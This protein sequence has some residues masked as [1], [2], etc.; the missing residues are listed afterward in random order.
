MTKRWS[1][2]RFEVSETRNPPLYRRIRMSRGW[3]KHANG[4]LVIN[5]EVRKDPKKIERK[6]VIGVTVID[7]F[8]FKRK[9]RSL[10]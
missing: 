6:K 3:M 8:W 4:S 10:F 5:T 7:I 9:E 2:W 1:D